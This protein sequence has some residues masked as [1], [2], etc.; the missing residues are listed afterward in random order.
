L[1]TQPTARVEAIESLP[2]NY[3]L[4]YGIFLLRSFSFLASL[5]P[6]FSCLQRLQ[7]A[8]HGF[9]KYPCC[10]CPDS[11]FIPPPWKAKLALGQ[12]K[13]PYNMVLA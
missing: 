2:D 11:H 8:L 5:L 6:F 7:G 12:L 13:Q 4:G 3:W 1:R 9:T 10:C